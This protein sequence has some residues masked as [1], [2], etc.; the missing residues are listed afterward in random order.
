MKIKTTLLENAY[1]FLNNSLH[2][3]HLATHKD[4][5]KEYKRYW[6]FSLVDIVQAMELM[7]KEVLRRENEFFIYEN[8]DK[9]DKTVSIS[10]ALHRLKNILRIELNQ[11]DE[12]KIKQAIELR[13]KIVHFES[14]LDIKECSRIYAILFEFLQSFHYRFL[15]EELHDKISPEYWEEEALLIEQFKNEFVL[16][17]GIKV[18][19][20]YPIEFVESQL[21]TSLK[22]DGKEFKRIKFGDEQSQYDVYKQSHCGDCGVKEGYYHVLGC[23]LEICPKCGGQM[24]SCSCNLDENFIIQ[25]E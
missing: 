8:I 23:D 13:N 9:P 15:G 4:Y 3:Y 1:A 2:F 14:E 18:H 17:N 20:H 24:I 12:I 10:K 22:I 25:E 7:F 16:Y 11:S 5:P 19:K 21:I 6:M